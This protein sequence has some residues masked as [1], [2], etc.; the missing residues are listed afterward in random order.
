[1]NPDTPTSEGVGGF[2]LAKTVKKLLFGGGAFW[3]LL[4]GNFKD[5]SKSKMIPKRCEN[6]FK[7]MPE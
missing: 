1:M 4:G 6:E 5:G 7:M 2:M 3:S